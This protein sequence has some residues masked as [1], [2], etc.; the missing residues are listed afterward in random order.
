MFSRMIPNMLLSVQKLELEISELV[1]IKM[2]KVL[3]GLV[4][5]MLWLFLSP[6]GC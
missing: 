1:L 3:E 2:K 6:P 4:W 5:E